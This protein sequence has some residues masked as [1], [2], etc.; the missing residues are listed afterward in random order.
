VAQP[1]RIVIVANPSSGRGR[2]Q[3]LIGMAQPM[4]RLFAEGSEIRISEGPEDAP[5][6]AR[7]AAEEGADIVAALGGDGMVGMVANGLVGTKAALAVIPGGT[8][9][10][11]A[12]FIGLA[13]KKPEQALTGLVDPEYRSIDVVKLDAADGVERW[14]VN[15]AGAGFD[16]EV[17]ETA[18]RMKS[19]VQ[20]TAKYVAAV[21]TTLR[22]F[23]AAQFTI[24]VDGEE[25]SLSGM[26]VAVGNGRSYGGGMKVTPDA[27][28]DDGLLEVCV[29][30]GMSRGAFLRAFPKVFRGTH[31][32][33]PRVESLRGKRVEIRCSKNYTVY[34]DGEAAGPLPATFEVHPGAL[35]LAV[36]S[37]KGA[38]PS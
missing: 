36:P 38:P 11:F 33:D 16:S 8:G 35:R 32:K 9:N 29:V 12:V 30:K 28:L 6:L 19:R 2:G 1:P 10:D 22:R 25:R 23:E 31:V 18:N 24:T 14:F 3:R 13:R 21:V 4:L 17:N 20:G 37:T 27:V 34:A 15:V 26:L 7:A 5:R